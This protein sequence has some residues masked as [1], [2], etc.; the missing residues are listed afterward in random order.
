MWLSVYRIDA[1]CP[2]MLTSKMLWTRAQLLG[3][4]EIMGMSGFKKKKKDKLVSWVIWCCSPF[5]QA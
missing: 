2:A 1:S 5:A 3:F 4:R